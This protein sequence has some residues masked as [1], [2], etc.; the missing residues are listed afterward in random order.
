VI[1]SLASRTALVLLLL[2]GSDPREGTAQGPGPNRSVILATTTSVFDTGLLDSI[3]P[4]FERHS[5]Y[6]VRVVAVGSGQA[7]AMGR[8]GDADVVLAH[9]PAAERAFMDAGYGTRRR[10]VASN[11]FTIAGPAGDPARVRAAPSAVEALRRVATAGQPFASRGDSSG[12]HAREL[13]LWQKGGG[14]LSWPGYLETGQGMAATLLIAS[15]RR[16]YALSDRATLGYFRGRIDL[17]ALRERE[18]DLRNVYH[19]IELNVA[20][21]PRLNAEGG[22]AFADFLVSQE[23]QQFLVQFGAS[24]LGEP[25]FIPAWGREPE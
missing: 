16:A 21:H 2:A 7:L 13:A 10:V 14:R 23:V 15:E 24:R 8:R 5:G 12:T 11:Y 18:P 4:I 20:D 17:V 3:L 6:H 22:R 25:M 1:V 19:V 9:S